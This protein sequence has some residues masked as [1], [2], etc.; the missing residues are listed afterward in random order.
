MESILRGIAVYLFLLLVFRIAGKRTLSQE[1]TFDLVLLLI[2]SETVQEAL[3]DG[4]HSITHAFTLVLL[5]TGMSVLFGYLKERFPWLDRWLEG[6]PRLLM[7][8][9]EVHSR[10]MLREHIDEDDIVAEARFSRGL[11]TLDKVKHVVLE[12]NGKLSVVPRE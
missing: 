4:D 9:G 10:R 1:T 8:D 3:I 2:I 12:K 5:L 6:S 11:E 7:H